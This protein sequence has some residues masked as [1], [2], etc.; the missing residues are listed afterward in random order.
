MRGVVHE[1]NEDASRTDKDE[2][3]TPPSLF[4]KLDERFHF[5]V[6]VAA[7]EE[8]KLCFYYFQNAFDQGWIP[9]RIV[10]S[11]K[12]TTW[13]QYSNS[14]VF[15]CNP[16]YSSGKILPFLQKGYS[17][18]L[19]GAIVVFLLP[20]DISTKWFDIC[21]NA[22]EWIRIKGRVQFNH[23]DGTPIKGSRSSEVLLLSSMKN[24]AGRLGTSS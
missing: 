10:A 9:K 24:A 6:D 16:P 12:Y 22:A 3:C 19:K 13:E 2:Q 1:R 18:S 5:D 11:S 14:G 21:M 4:K 17:E 7:T 20:A 8:N 23:A 15:F